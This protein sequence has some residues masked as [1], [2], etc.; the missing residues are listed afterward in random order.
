MHI[1]YSEMIAALVITVAYFTL[2]PAF[3]IFGAAWATVIGFFARF[4]WT[5]RKG[6]QFYDMELPWKKV[7]LTA[8]LAMLALSLSLLVPENIMISILSRTMILVLFI[9]VFF[10]SPILSRSDKLEI[11][12]MTKK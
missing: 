9:A 7:L 5:N 6:K 11:S 8:A 4:Y 3:G 2:I 12:K 1:A 10:I